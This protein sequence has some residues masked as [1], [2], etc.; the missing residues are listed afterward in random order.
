MCMDTK[1]ILKPKNSNILNTPS[2]F[3]NKK[4][5]LYSSIKPLI[6]Q[7]HYILYIQNL[8]IHTKTPTHP[9]TENFQQKNYGKHLLQYSSLQIQSG[10]LLQKKSD[11]FRFLI[12]LHYGHSFRQRQFQ[13][14][15][16]INQW[17][18]PHSSQMHLTQQN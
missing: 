5:N 2:Q 18:N 15:S 8:K 7:S 6:S 1:S 12:K 16:L 11:H 17:R 3:L 9:S 4:N 14:S 10:K 13:C